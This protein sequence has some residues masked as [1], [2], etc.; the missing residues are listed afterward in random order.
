MPLPLWKYKKCW[1]CNGWYLLLIE[2]FFKKVGGSFFDNISDLKN[3][4]VKENAE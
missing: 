4:V 2:G 1:L 3:L